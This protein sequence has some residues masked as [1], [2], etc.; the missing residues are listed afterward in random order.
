MMVYTERICKDSGDHSPL[1]G[2]GALVVC[3]KTVLSSAP[4][5]SQTILLI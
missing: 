4:L 1:V 2:W 3:S 5:F